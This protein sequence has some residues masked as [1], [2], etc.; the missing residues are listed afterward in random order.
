MATKMWLLLAW[1]QFA[2][3]TDKLQSLFVRTKGNT[4]TKCG[5]TRAHLIGANLT[6]TKDQ[7][8]SD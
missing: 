1:N 4:C 5:F 6:S 3:A 7:V 8:I 2:R